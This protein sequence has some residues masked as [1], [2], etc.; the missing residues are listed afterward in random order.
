MRKNRL[1]VLTLCHD[2]YKIARVFFLYVTR[3]LLNCNDNPEILAL[4]TGNQLCC[5]LALKKQINEGTLNP[6]SLLGY[7][8]L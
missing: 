3:N 1:N 8:F 4:L 7:K 6:K 5:S 2:L